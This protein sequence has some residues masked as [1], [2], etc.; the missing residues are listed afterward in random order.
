MCTSPAGSPKGAVYNLD[1]TPVPFL[2]APAHPST[3]GKEARQMEGLPGFGGAT[4]L[5]GCNGPGRL[6]GVRK[7]V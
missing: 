3:W 6:Y 2:T 5:Q 4:G 7:S 1:P